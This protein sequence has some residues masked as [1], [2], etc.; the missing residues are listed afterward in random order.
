[1][2]A[3]LAFGLLVAAVNGGLEKRIEKNAKDK[4]NSKMG[5]LFKEHK[6]CLF[7]EVAVKS[8]NLYR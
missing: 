6:N 1:M 2:V 8:C 4:L 5:I 7:E 3:A